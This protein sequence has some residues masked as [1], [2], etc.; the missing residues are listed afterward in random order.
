MGATH[1]ALLMIGGAAAGSS[2]KL[3]LHFEEGVD[4]AIVDSSG[5]SKTATKMS[6]FNQTAG[7]AKW[8]T[9]GAFMSA[10]GLTVNDSDFAL[11]TADFIIDFWMKQ[12]NGFPIF[13]RCLL[14][15]KYSGGV[16]FRLYASTGAN[17]YKV[18]F[19]D[20]AGAVK[21]VSGTLSDNTWY[22]V[23]V[24]RI[25]GTTYVQ[26][27]S[28]VAFSFTDSTDY[29]GQSWC[30]GNQTGLASTFNGGFDE[31]RVA[32]GAS[33]PASMPVTVPTGPYA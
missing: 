10:G 18:S 31:I 16:G 24:A 6:D 30:F 33:V 2:G 5:T 26:V 7:Y 29:T 14:D 8:G 28:A 1:Q 3:L 25:S 19:V 4:A 13:D 9:Y 23:A 11:G 20:N 27:D 12:V 32:S 22:F 21:G 17:A 15:T